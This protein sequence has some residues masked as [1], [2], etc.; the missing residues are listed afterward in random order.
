VCSAEWPKLA[1][2]A[3]E[4]QYCTQAGV[5]PEKMANAKDFVTRFT[6]K[7]GPIQVYA[8]YSYDATMTLIAAMQKAN[9]TDPAK[10]LPELAK[11]SYDGVTAKI[12]FDDHGDT[13]NGAITL[14]QVKDG[15]LMPMAM[16]VGGKTEKVDAA[17]A[18]PAAPASAPMSGMK[19]DMKATGDSMKATGDK[20]KS[21]IENPTPPTPAN[22]DTMKKDMKGQ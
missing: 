5:P 16:N 2:G 7:Y 15:Q 18:A 14:Y 9:S 12:E 6:A 21:A 8:P 1:G 10:Y 3:A 20:M 19:S 17:P 11:I 4:G 22:A 13:K